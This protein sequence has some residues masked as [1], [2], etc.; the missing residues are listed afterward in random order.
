MKYVKFFVCL[1]EVARQEKKERT[2][3]SAV[4]NAFEHAERCQIFDKPYS[5]HVIQ[6]TLNVEVHRTLEIIVEA[7]QCKATPA[8]TDQSRVEKC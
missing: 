3:S 1:L 4:A 6:A 7:L 2:K 8:R 5:F